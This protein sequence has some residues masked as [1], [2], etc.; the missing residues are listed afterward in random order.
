MARGRED[1]AGPLL[2]WIG[3]LDSWLRQTGCSPER[4]SRAVNAFARLSAWMAA[5]G[6]GVADLDEDVI[7]EH[8]RTER[9]RS[10]ARS[11]AAA[12]YLPLAKRFLASQ[13][14]LVLRAP[15]SRNL[16]GIQ[17]LPAGPLV[18]LVSELVTWLRAEGY[19]PGMALSVAETAARLGAWMGAENLDMAD[20]DEAVLQR[21]VAAQ[22]S[23]S[24]WHPSSARRIVTVRKFFLATGRLPSVDSPA[25]VLDVVGQCL[26]A[27]GQHVADERGAGAGWIRE[28][29]RWAH[30]FLEQ[31]RGLDGQIH[32]DRVDVR[33]VNEY[34]AAAGRGYSLSSRRH[35]V[36]AMRS[37]VAWAFRAGLVPTL[38]GAA[39]LAPGRPQ[40]GL[41]QALT[42][43]QVEAV[44]AAADRS[45]PLGRRDCAI[46]VMISRLGLR[47]GEVASLWLDDI[48]WHHGQLTVRGKGGRILSLPLPDDVGCALVEYLRDRRP[49]GVGRSVFLRARPPLIGLTGKGISSAIAQLARQAG[50]GTVHA[51]R[52]RHSAATAVLAGGGSLIEARELLGHTRTDTTMVY[53]R[54]DLGALATLAIPWGR[55]PS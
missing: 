11:P 33:A 3:P 40:P 51:H 1:L 25:P 14:V 12:Q 27:R 20:L 45:V 46:A 23:G 15:V 43:E 50:L 35:L 39:V 5:R 44:K 30:G 28:Q 9:Q 6:L 47:A 52:L 2:M 7:D 16:G 21:F 34:V 22:T 55:I 26:Q 8:I 32:W 49:D 31:L 53:A 29:A 18:S 4:A 10:G 54:V 42:V 48:D 36:A 37:L 41:P 17:R 13:G 38:M 24:D 19:A